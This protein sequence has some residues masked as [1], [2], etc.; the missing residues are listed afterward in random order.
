MV[1]MEEESNIWKKKY[2]DEVKVLRYK[3]E[4]VVDTNG[5]VLTELTDQHKKLIDDLKSELKIP[6][7]ELHN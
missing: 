2:A 7:K 4:N 5:K 1:E 6:V 3:I